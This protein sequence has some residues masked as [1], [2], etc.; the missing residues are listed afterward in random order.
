M[1]IKKT[2]RELAEEEGEKGGGLAS[3]TKSKEV[4]PD[5][6]GRLSTVVT[7]ATENIAKLNVEYSKYFSGAEKKP[8]VRAR[9][10]LEKLITEINRLKKHATSHSLQFKV[11]AVLD[12]FLTY[13]ISW[14]KRLADL[15]KTR[16]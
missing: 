16:R 3:L 4:Q 14:D 5:Y 8:P 9:E 1:A 12:S 2:L 6:Q 10:E 13:R 7:M 15:E 11:N